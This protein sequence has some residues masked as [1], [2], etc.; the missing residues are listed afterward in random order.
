M[1]NVLYVIK[2]THYL[3]LYIVKFEVAEMNAFLVVTITL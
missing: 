2:S 3:M 1:L